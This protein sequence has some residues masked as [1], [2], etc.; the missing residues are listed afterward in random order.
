MSRENSFSAPL[1]ARA[2]KELLDGFPVE[3]EQRFSPSLATVLTMTAPEGPPPER[4]AR[5]VQAEKKHVLRGHAGPVQTLTFSPDSMSLASGSEDKTVRVWDVASG[6]LKNIFAGHL[7]KVYGLCYI[8]S[9][10]ILFSCSKDKM[11]MEWDMLRS[12][13]R[14]NLEGHSNVVWSVCMAQEG[15]IA[16]SVSHDETIRF[17][18]TM[19][20]QLLHTIKGGPSTGRHKAWPLKGQLLHTIKGGPGT[21][22]HTATIYIIKGSPSIQQDRE[23]R[24]DR[25]RV[26]DRYP[27]LISGYPVGREVTGSWDET[28]RL[29]DV[30]T[31]NTLCIFSANSKVNTVF[32]SPDGDCV[33]SGGDDRIV[34]MWRIS[35]QECFTNLS[36]HTDEVTGV[37]ISPDGK[38]M[39]SCAN[40]KTI[41]T[42]KVIS[43]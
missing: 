12:E 2:S 19:K 1:S 8:G 37:A 16:I 38:F 40:D 10:T 4:K 13:H 33:V 17:W 29:W 32:V 43:L 36:G 42:Y 15:Q 20:G 3:G 39:A 18:D 21:G 11:I 24:D 34:R 22:H 23:Y 41:I 31:G 28:M 26:D 35:T 30:E 14:K 27:G 9:G 25:R 6:N 7:G 5:I